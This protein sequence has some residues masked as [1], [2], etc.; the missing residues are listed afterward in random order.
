MQLL[1]DRLVIAKRSSGSANWHSCTRL[2]HYMLR[3]PL[4]TIAAYKGGCT[5]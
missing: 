1:I 3:I 2:L 4:Y 5:R